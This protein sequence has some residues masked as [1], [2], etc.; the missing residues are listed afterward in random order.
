M[1][2]YNIRKVLVGLDLKTDNA[3]QL[4]SRALQFANTDEI[5]VLHVF[6][7]TQ[8]YKKHY[9]SGDFSNS[10]A[11]LS[12]ITQEVDEQLK[13]TCKPFSIEN[14]HIEN[15][16]VA[17][18][19]HKAAQ[20]QVDLVVIGTHGRHGWR[21]LLGSTPNAV[22]HG[23]PCDVLA[24]KV[25]EIGS[26]TA[27]Q[28]YQRV[29]VAVDL[30]LVSYDVMEHTL[31]A[32]KGS[33]AKIQICYIGDVLQSKT[34]ATNARGNLYRFGDDFD[35][36]AEDCFY[37]EGTVASKIHQLS[38]ELNSD[39]VVVGTHGKQGVRL[40]LGS[41]ANAVMHGAHCDALSVRV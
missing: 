29:L 16:S 10:N 4:L 6:N 17:D 18:S 3:P 8:H 12:A 5:E 14:Y 1:D 38:A 26:Q 34:E 7:D 19:I 9:S 15:G 11:L 33:N 23:T 32:I 25:S 2:A 24:V 21:L 22:V 31:A 37:R 35:I 41:T 36:A 13:N 39:L 40:L 27:T 20:N 28:S 30:E